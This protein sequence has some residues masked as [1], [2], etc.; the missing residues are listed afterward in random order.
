[1]AYSMQEVKSNTCK[2]LVR[3][4]LGRSRCRWWIISKCH[5]EIEWTVVD[6][7]YVA[8]NRDHWRALLSTVMNVWV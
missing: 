1:M 2:V 4:P 5:R 7:I 8:Q 6:W 3:K